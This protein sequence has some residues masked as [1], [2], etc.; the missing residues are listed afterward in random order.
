[1]AEVKNEQRQGW[2]LPLDAV[3]D[4]QARTI[5]RT[6]SRGKGSHYIDIRMRINGDFEHF[7]ADWIKHM[8]PVSPGMLGQQSARDA[9]VRAAKKWGDTDAANHVAMLA[10]ELELSQAIAA[11]AE[12]KKE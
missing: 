10:S 2:F 7:E 8:V 5:A 4:L 12:G 11:L 3:N 1:M 9:V 6:I